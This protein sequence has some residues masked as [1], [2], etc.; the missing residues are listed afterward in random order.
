MK[1]YQITTDGESRLYVAESLMEAVEQDFA[2]F[3]SENSDHPD[4]DSFGNRDYYDSL[5][6]QIVLVGSVQLP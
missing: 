2:A 1:V 3:I 5:L 6:D 4:F